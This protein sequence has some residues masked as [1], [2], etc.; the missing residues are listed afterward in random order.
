MTNQEAE[1]LAERIRSQFP[2]HQIIVEKSGR[3][4][5][6]FIRIAPPGAFIGE[7]RIHSERE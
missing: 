5:R 2:F 6:A 7:L 4:T 3:I 1:E